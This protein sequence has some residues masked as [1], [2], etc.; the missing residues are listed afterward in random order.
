MTT[1]VARSRMPAPADVVFAW[2]ERPGALERLTPPWQRVRVLERSGGIR[3]GG[4]LTLEVRAGPFARRWV[5]VHRDYEA[6]RRFA[7]EQVEGPF[8]RWVHVH[9]VEPAG[10]GAAV[11][12]DRVDYA[13][14]LGAIGE[15]AG[16]RRVRA[17]LRRVFTYRHRLLAGD[18]ARHRA[19]RGPALHVAISGASGLL[20]SRLAAFLTTGGHRVTR[21]VRRAPAGPDEARWDPG[22]GQVDLT[23]LEGADALVHLAGESIAAGRWTAAVKARIR[24]S[25]VEG[26]RLL[27]GALGRL[28]RR[29]RVL[30][31]A[32]AIGFYGDRGG[33]ELDESSAPGQ[34]FLADTCQAWE[35]AALAAAPL[36]MRVVLARLG[37]VLS[38]AGGALAKLV[39]PFSLG[40]GGRIGSGRQVMSWVALDDALGALCWALDAEA[41][42]G[43]VN[44][45][46][47]AAVTNAEFVR[48][49]GAV[50]RRPAVLPVPGTAVR[51]MFGEMG[52]DLLGGQRV[53]PR[54]L[55]DSGF[56]FRHATLADTLAFELGRFSRS[57]MDAVCSPG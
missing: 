36:G 8:A 13:L 52:N 14:P 11:L 46:A 43:P 38:G 22:G 56:Q 28:R 18:L 23:P 7:D 30:V 31:S 34:G 20:G 35:A 6:G 25:R 9:R 2:H 15:L 3:D 41:L 57:E 12:E 33:A 44:V 4:R 48:T 40:V 55:L 47:P 1:F 29:P 27:V 42:G 5:A 16:G 45:V 10:E 49:L 17:G 53:S 19:R 51:L 39:P 54:R 32:S 24:D 21:L 26:T 37:I 50:L